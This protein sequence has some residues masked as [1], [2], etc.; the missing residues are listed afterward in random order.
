MSGRQAKWAGELGAYGISYALRS[1]IKGQV[2]AD[3]LADSMTEGNPV[4]EKVPD[5]EE[6]LE[7]SKARDAL[8]VTDLVSEPKMWKLYTDGASNDHGSGAWLILINPEGAEYSYALPLKFTNSNN[9]TEYEDLFAR[10]RIETKMKVKK[11]TCV[12]RFKV[13]GKP[14]RRLVRSQSHIPRE[15][16]RKA[17]VLSKLAAVQFD[18]L[19]KEVLMEVLNE[20]SV[21][22]AKVNMVLEEEGRT[23]MTPIKDYIE[24]G[25][26]PNDPTKARTLK[27]NK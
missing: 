26:L 22:I 6:V 18:P 21:D 10:L 14:C 9:D 7:S 15:Q 2:L 3:F 19:T 8:I 16:N 24:K 13:G 12:C 23:W 5:S 1:A 27:E 20:G 4:R 11:R 25:N 17:D